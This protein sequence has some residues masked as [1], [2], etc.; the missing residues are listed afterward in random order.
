MKQTILSLKIVAASLVLAGFAGQTMAAG[1]Q[2]AEANAVNI[3]DAGAGGAAIAEDASTSTY[4]PAGL[5]DIKVPQV[6]LSAV[7]IRSKADFSGTST[8]FSK[9]A[10]G[11]EFPNSGTAS[12]GDKAILPAFHLAAPIND[13][14]VF[15]F[16]LTAPFG[17]ATKYATDSILRYEA[18]ESDVKVMDFSPSVGI[19]VNEQLSVGLGVDYEKMDA[20]LNSVAGIPA[21][22]PKGLQL[23]D[24]ISNNQASSWAFGWHAG[25]LYKFTPATR[26]GLNYASKVKHH[27]TGTSTLSGPVANGSDDLTADVTLPA[28]TTLSMAHELNSNWTLLGSVSYTQWD[29]VQNITLNNVASIDP[30]KEALTKIPVTLPMSFRNTWRVAAGANYKFNEQ[31]KFR[32]GLGYDQSPVEAEYRGIRL[33]D[34]DRIVAA[35]GAHYQPT[36]QLGVDVGYTHLFIKDG[37]INHIVYMGGQEV[38]TVG[39]SKNAADLLGL[40]LTWNLA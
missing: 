22:G 19:K 30:V 16:S 8:W 6:V 24:A 35:V 21:I 9:L 7:G 31:W 15:G 23:N 11:H 39:T 32:A 20:A 10:P 3:G 38:H 12:G 4:N 1:F 2:L 17:L 28:S 14:F 36:K 34:A 40:Q 25:V 13:R 37:D 33:P 27:L 29:V 26:V 5:T 18:T